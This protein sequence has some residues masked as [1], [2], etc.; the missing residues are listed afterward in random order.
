MSRQVN[1]A[2]LVLLNV[3]TES[4][5]L[6]VLAVVLELLYRIA[7]FFGLVESG[8]EYFLLAGLSAMA[9]VLAI[10]RAPYAYRLLRN[11]GQ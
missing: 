3:F 1:L 10:V 2:V 11:K 6:L 8:L 5:A 7:V 9:V 4:V